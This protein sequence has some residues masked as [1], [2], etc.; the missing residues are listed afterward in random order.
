MGGA[1]LFMCSKDGGY[2]NGNVLIT[3]GGGLSIIEGDATRD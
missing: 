1:V 2:M 3:D